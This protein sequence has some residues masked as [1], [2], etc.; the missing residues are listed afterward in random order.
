MNE[1][2]ICIANNKQCYQN[3]DKLVYKLEFL[4]CNKLTTVFT[5]KMYSFYTIYI[6]Y[7][8]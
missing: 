2:I 3:K 6:L 5:V 1:C 4:F 8:I 7:I